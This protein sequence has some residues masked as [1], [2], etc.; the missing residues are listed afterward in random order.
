MAD[1]AKA[2][3]A[4]QD[5]HGESAPNNLSMPPIL[6]PIDPASHDLS[7]YRISCHVNSVYY[8]QKLPG[9]CDNM[10]AAVVLELCFDQADADLRYAFF[11]THALDVSELDGCPHFERIQMSTKQPL[12]L[13]RFR[14]IDE[15]GGDV[16]W[17]FRNNDGN[18]FPPSVKLLLD[19]LKVG[20][21]QPFRFTLQILPTLTVCVQ[22]RSWWHVWSTLLRAKEEKGQR[23]WSCNIEA[24]YCPDIAK[25]ILL[26]YEKPQEERDTSRMVGL[27]A[28][29]APYL[30]NNRLTLVPLHLLRATRD[31]ISCAQVS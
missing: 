14:I 1:T 21:S 19:A 9:G 7:K 6:K 18:Y 22:P 23:G 31:S 11:P 13:Q 26:E 5:C 4:T 24:D 17:H 16:W 29:V 3:H 25:N 15:N 10:Y 30:P 28:A 27:C 20:T 8:H 12:I 2:Q